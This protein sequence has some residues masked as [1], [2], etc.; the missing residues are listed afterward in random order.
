MQRLWQNIKASIQDNPRNKNAI[1]STTDL[2]KGLSAPAQ[3]ALQSAGIR[4]L[5]DL[6]RFTESDVA[7]LHG[8]GKNALE[9]L[10]AALAE[11]GLAWKKS[12]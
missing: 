12:H 11:A 8:I 1:M 10:A 7:H 3:R 5:N 4:T 9:K 2:P 6:T